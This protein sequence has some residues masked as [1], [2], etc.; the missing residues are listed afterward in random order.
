MK[1][2]QCILLIK[3]YVSIYLRQEI[4]KISSWNMILYLNNILNI[5]MILVV[6]EKSIILTHTMSQL[7]IFLIC[8]VLN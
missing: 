8:E 3:N 6:E 2:L 4:Y 1:F 7:I 5:L